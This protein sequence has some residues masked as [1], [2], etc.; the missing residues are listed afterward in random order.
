M[1]MAQ[2]SFYGYLKSQSLDITKQPTLG[3]LVLD[4]S[5]LR[6]LCFIPLQHLWPPALFTY[7]SVTN[8]HKPKWSK[9]TFITSQFLCIANP[10]A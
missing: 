5:C 3:G 2:S 1:L 8:F 9:T 4:F 7:C 6:F 10:V